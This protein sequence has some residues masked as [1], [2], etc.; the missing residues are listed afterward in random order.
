MTESEAAI[1]VAAKIA[2]RMMYLFGF[3]GDWV[4]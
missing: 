3:I 1:K 2:Q 4:A